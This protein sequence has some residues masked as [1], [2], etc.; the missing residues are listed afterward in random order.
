[1]SN[2]LNFAI[3]VELDEL[4]RDLK[5]ASGKIEDFTKRNEA[6]FQRLGQKM[7]QLGKG[8]SVAVTLPL[9]ALGAASVKAASDAE[10]TESKFKTI[11]SNIAASATKAQDELINSYG[12]SRQASQQ[13]LGD[14]GDL[15]TGFGFTQ[16]AALDLA[17]GVNKLAVDLASFTN[18]SGG[19]AGASAALTKALLGERESV[20]SLGISIL[21]ADVQAK[22]LENTQKGLTFE[23]ERQAKAFATL[24]IAQEQSKNAIGD[25]ARTSDS[26][27]N[28]TRLLKARLS[29]LSV[30]FGKILLPAATKLVNILEK[31]IDKFSKFDDSTKR[32]IV[33]V[34]A[35]AAAI[36]PVL[37]VLGTLISSIKSVVAVLAVLKAAILSNPI[38]ALAVAVTAVASAALLLNSRLTSLTNAQESFASLTAIAAK[39]IAKEKSELDLL[40]TTAKNEKISKDKRLEA[41]KDLNRIV[42]EYNDNLTLETINTKK[43]DDATKSY[44]NRL[45]QKAKAQAAQKKL[46]EVEEK[47]LDL[48]LG[49]GDAVK[50][51]IWQ[52]AAN[53]VKTFGN[54]QLFASETAKT[55]GKNVVQETAELEKL[56]NKLSEFLTDNSDLLGTFNDEIEETI[57]SINNLTGRAKVKPIQVP[58]Q[59]TGVEQTGGN[60]QS[61]ETG[62][63][64]FIDEISKKTQFLFQLL[65]DFDQQAR[66]LVEGSIAGTFEAL[67]NTI[68]NALSSGA[69]VIEAF[70]KTI[71]V[72][73][74]NFLS[75]FGS[76]LIK[77]AV[78]SQAFDKLKK[79]LLSG[80]GTP[81]A[82]GLAIAAGLAL[83]AV[84]G[85]IASQ[86]SGG[87]GSGGG[88]SAST[89][90]V[91]TSQ[92][93]AAGGR[94][95]EFVFRISG[96]DLVTVIDRNRNN[97]DRI[98]G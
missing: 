43:A 17:S 85:A 65:Q 21:E 95:N 41:I 63:L 56:K 12:L 84:G 64:P 87:G 22:V 32:T 72:A 92:S 29:D 60:L 62:S 47:L 23:S 39:N 20:K 52:N 35:I 10:E 27:A 71:L 69:N 45:L 51:S 75:D 44:V 42:P 54:A 7:T 83:K 31:V 97:T 98:G 14:T 50:P 66:D 46:I 1:M 55:V 90:N 49:Q 82:A 16:T 89:P 9:L 30:E 78:A 5:R 6:R 34:A 48:Y 24:Q 58:I 19:A 59:T 38:G 3:G 86:A 80:I 68:A 67:G 36:G 26:F 79:T 76:L 11:F 61:T 77:Y 91:N 2:N 70:G 28:K 25:Y 93:F 37:I 18:F 74:G 73:I 88:A 81:A 57:K 4:S 96:R 40:L 8:L 15:L 33:V 94:G 53:A 13:L